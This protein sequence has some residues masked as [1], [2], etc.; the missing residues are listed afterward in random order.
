[1]NYK[2]VY[3]NI[4]NNRK[5]NS[6]YGYTET[7][8]ILPKSLGGKD[9]KENLVDLSAREHFICHLLLIKMYPE[10]SVEWI[11]MMKAF[12]CMMFRQSSNQQRYLNSRWYSFYREKF[13]KAQSINQLGKG[14]SNYGTCWVINLDTGDIKKIKKLE[15][16]DY[17]KRGY[18]RGRTLNDRYRMSHG[19]KKL[20][21]EEKEINKQKRIEKQIKTMKEKGPQLC[22][23]NKETRKRKYFSISEEPDLSIWE[24]TWSKFNIQEVRKMLSEKRTWKQIAEYYHV[25]YWNIYTWYR[26]NKYLF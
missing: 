9:D 6:F 10:G 13:S 26:D 1:M 3:E 24:P 11:K 14:N 22:Y 23:I 12:T 16:E 19:Y 5:Q 18:V 25:S 21:A 2:K 8:H 4:I 17:F 7:H 20:S 15:L